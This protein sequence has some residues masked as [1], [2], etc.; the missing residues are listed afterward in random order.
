MM[1]TSWAEEE[2]GG[3][4]LGDQRLTK[5]L[6][7]L[8]D[9]FA[10]KPTASIP[11]ACTDAAETKAVYRFFEQSREDKRALSWRNVL[12][13]HIAQTE[14]RMRQHPVVLC[15]QDTTEL[16][17]NGQSIE[18]LGP[19]SFEAQR[20]MY[21]HPT[22]AVTPGREPLGVTDAWMWAREPK[23][24]DGIRPG[25][26]ES[27][28]WIEGYERVAESALTMPETRLVYV[29]D[30]EADILALMQ[31]AHVLDNPADWLIRAQHNRCLPEGGKLWERVGASESFGE[32]E[33]TQASRKGQAERIVRQELRAQRVTLPDGQGGELAITCIIAKEIAPPEGI[34]PVEWRLITNRSADTLEAIIELIDWYRCRW[35]IEIFFDVLKNG[36]RIEALQLGSYAKLEL[37][38]TVYM[39]IAWRISR[40]VRLARTQPELDARTLF[41]E[42][43]CVGAWHLAKK[44][45]PKT[46]LTIRDVIR[47]IAK[48]GGFL[49]RKGDGEPGVRT[50]WQGFQL[51][52]SFVNGVEYMRSVYAQ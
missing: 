8:A 23:G 49:G 51:L 46:P 6:I 44:P 15:L 28:R 21:L 2:F 34:E 10:D 30:R 4:Q 50:L 31:R 19:L 26:C 11:G 29:A 35:M 1:S 45:V 16:D 25:L 39:V 24:V 47:Q 36:C 37:A 3:A 18:G 38:L 17:F 27:T 7:K 41:T 14:A 43:E 5:R 52:R 22:C 33:F 32:L 13:P 9:R 48:L 20:G 40:L 12:A 42:D